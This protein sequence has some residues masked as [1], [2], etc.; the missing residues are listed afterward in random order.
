[1][2]QH[3]AV[4]MWTIEE[5]VGELIVSGGNGAVDLE[6]TEH[7]L[8]AIAL[9]IERTVTG[10]EALDD[11]GAMRSGESGSANPVSR[12]CAA[13]YSDRSRKSRPESSIV[14]LTGFSSATGPKRSFVIVR[15]HSLVP[16]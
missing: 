15:L 12:A 3:L 5:A 14:S 13:E 2:S 7:P 1:M 16:E 6:V 10:N 9:F 11:R 8:D 4:A